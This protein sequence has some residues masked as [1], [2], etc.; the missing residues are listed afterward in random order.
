MIN[1][2]AVRRNRIDEIFSAALDLPDGE[3]ESYLAVACKD[4]TS[5]RNAVRRLL[6]AS[7]APCHALEPG[8]AHQGPLW[9]QLAA[10]LI[11]GR[12]IVTGDRIGVYEII[13]E[14]GSGGM[15]VVYQARRADGQYEQEVALKILKEG[16]NSKDLTLRFQQER[17]ILASLNHPGIARLIDGGVTRDG[18]PVIVMEQVDGEPIDAYCDRHRLTVEERLQLFVEV[19]RAVHY[20]HQNL[21]VHRDLKPSNILVTGDGQVKLLDFGIAKLLDHEARRTAAPATRSSVRVL[22]PEYAS[23]EQVRGGP[24]TTASDIYQLGLL[25]Y[26]LLCGSRAYRLQGHTPSEIERMICDQEPIPPSAAT[27]VAKNAG[28]NGRQ[29]QRISDLRQTRPERLRKRLSG[30]L[31][32]IVLMALRKE[33]LRRYGTVE[34]LGQDIERHLAGRPVS[35]RRVTFGYRLCKLIK[36][37]TVAVAGSLSMLLLIAAVIFFY[38][39]R[40]ADERDR[41]Q[42][43]AEKANQVSTYLEG[44]FQATDSFQSRGEEISTAE[45]LDQEVQRVA[46]ELE[47]Q[48]DLQVEMKILLANIYCR[49]GM[50]DN[51]GELLEQVVSTR[52]QLAGDQQ[53]A[54]ASSLT[55]LADIYFNQGRFE[56]AEPLYQQAIISYEKVLDSEDLRLADARW[57]LAELY[58]RWSRYPEAEVLL[59]QIVTVRELHLGKDHPAVIESLASLL[60]VQE[61]FFE[62]EPLYRKAL[63]AKRRMLGSDHVDVA[64]CLRLVGWTAGARGHWDEAERYHREELAILEHSFGP[65]HYDLGYTLQRLANCAE[66]RGQLQEASELFERALKIQRATLGPDH[67]SMAATFH[68]LARFKAAIGDFS[69]AEELELRAISIYQEAYGD[70]HTVVAPLFNNLAYFALVRGQEAETDAYCRRALEILEPRGGR[71]TTVATVLDTQACLNINQGRLSLAESQ[72][73]RSIATLEELLF[74]DHPYLAEILMNSARLSS[75]QGKYTKAAAHFDRA[76]TIARKM[77]QSDPESMACRNLLALILV[78]QGVMYQQ[79]GDEKQA[80]TCWHEADSLTEPFTGETQAVAVLST[81]TMVLLRLARV[82]EA[83]PLAEKVLASGWRQSDLVEL[84]RQHGLLNS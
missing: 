1:D 44:L 37:H 65:N 66:V 23:P 28:K 79:L 8:K 45:M 67:P 31:D 57:G 32:T 75:M 9:D 18:R 73:T 12:S 72:L 81:R 5:L 17:Q 24:I 39:S 27:G 54:S 42:L 15:A 16:R 36:R 62:A 60:F 74:Q 69:A 4:D 68:S 40:L 2:P 49:L 20:A 10:E 43:E 19:V 46:T 3:R 34:Q 11:N 77:Y 64:L 35:A 55:R 26:E 80:L 83:R 71:S 14:L 84:C 7:E 25:L 29:P 58:L 47:D 6:A 78:W 53:L 52:S 70:A 33:P 51:A 82:A 56:E 13:C 30:D 63:E 21:V 22:T 61:H 38:T 41:A 48:P 59:K 50:F 76:L